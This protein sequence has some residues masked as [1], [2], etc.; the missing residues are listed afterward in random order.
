MSTRTSSATAGQP[1]TFIAPLDPRRGRL[2]QLIWGRI[3]V[4]AAVVALW[5]LAVGFKWLD[6][7]FFSSPAAIALRLWQLVV[8]G[9]L[10]IHL[11]ITFWEVVLGF[12]VGAVLGV[13]CGMAMAAGRLVPEI[14]D[15]YIMA[16][17]GLPRAALAPLFVVWFGIGVASKVAVGASIVFFLCL[18]STYSGMRL[19]DTMLLQAVKALGA[20]KRQLL[21]KV[22]VPYAMPWIIAGL[23]SSVGMAL[24]GTIVGEFVAASRGI[25]W[26]IAY[27]GG[28]YDT[29]GVMVGLVVLGVMSVV[30]NALIRRVEARLLKWK[31][32]IAV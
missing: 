24:I 21:F 25:G 20:T 6:F 32:E 7:Y 11:A 27:A 30:L 28:S 13:A 31:P 15:P 14:L 19:T 8:S 29:T 3:I 4:F 26:Y 23:K 2:G 18:F 16:L 1:K 17:Y 9:R 5:Q 10:F 12:M 22:R